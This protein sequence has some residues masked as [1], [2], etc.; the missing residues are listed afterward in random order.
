MYYQLLQT[1]LPHGI[2]I[3][4]RGAKEF[5]IRRE[6]NFQVWKPQLTTASRP[7]PASLL[8]TLNDARDYFCCSSV[9]N[10]AS[11]RCHSI[12]FGRFPFSSFK[13]CGLSSL[14]I[15]IGFQG[16]VTSTCS[17]DSQTVPAEQRYKALCCF[18]LRWIQSASFAHSVPIGMCL[19][20]TNF[21]G[22]QLK[23]WHN[24]AVS[25]KIVNILFQFTMG[26][27]QS[28]AKQMFWREISFI[29]STRNVSTFH[30][31]CHAL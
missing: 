25:I 18:F 26:K 15:Y 21:P 19:Q 29:R 4:R 11:L 2:R 9:W 5:L 14:L 8:L 3:I 27:S 13:C 31:R 7:G 24:C 6:A 23:L 28:L 16:C 30:M 22:Q 17:M 1:Q 12:A 20:T 10:M